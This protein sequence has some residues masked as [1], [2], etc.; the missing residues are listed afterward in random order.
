MEVK[1][2]TSVQFKEYFKTF[3]FL[4][5]QIIPGSTGRNFRRKYYGIFCLIYLMFYFL[6]I[7]QSSSFLYNI[8]IYIIYTTNFMLCVVILIKNLKRLKLCIY[9]HTHTELWLPTPL[10]AQL[11]ECVHLISF[12]SSLLFPTIG[13][14]SSS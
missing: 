7:V 14:P 6:V 3:P 8:F 2:V 12:I 9:I 1:G 13:C 10:L 11:L 5:L 4:T